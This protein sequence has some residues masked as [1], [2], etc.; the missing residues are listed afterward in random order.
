MNAGS[1]VKPRKAQVK[2]KGLVAESGDF[3]GKPA[4][5]KPLPT[6]SVTESPAA[7]ISPSQI[8]AGKIS[9]EVKAVRGSTWLYATNENGVSIFSGQVSKGD[10]KVFSEA[11]QVN[12]RVGNAGGVDIA[13]NGKGV[14]SVGANGEVVNLTYNAN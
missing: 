10:R 12:L 7:T 1:S 4:A 8:A 14:G 6:S 2:D 11:K 13:V 3:G 9:V 5:V